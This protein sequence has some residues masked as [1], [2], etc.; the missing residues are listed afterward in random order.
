MNFQLCHTNWFDGRANYMYSENPLY[1][2]TEHG[3]WPK[4]TYSYISVDNL[5]NLETPLC[6][7]PL[8]VMWP[9]VPNL[10]ILIF[11]NNLFNPETPLYRNPLYTKHGLWSHIYS[12][13]WTTS[14]NRKPLYTG[15]FSI[16]NMACGPKS[17][18]PL[19]NNLFKL[20]SHLNQTACLISLL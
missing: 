18:F 4:S 11:I 9:V 8:C 20:E 5:F 19:I 12:F 1:W 14:L 17:T 15:I 10:L 6:R 7:N 2:Y 3:L 16:T 13:L